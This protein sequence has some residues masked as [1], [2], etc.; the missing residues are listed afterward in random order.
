MS[1]VWQA[2][3]APNVPDADVG[4]LLQINWGYKLRESYNAGERELFHGCL[5][6]LHLTFRQML[7]WCGRIRTVFLAQAGISVAVRCF[8]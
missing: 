5:Q 3:Q 1:A 6:H 2:Q 4:K 8:I 7:S